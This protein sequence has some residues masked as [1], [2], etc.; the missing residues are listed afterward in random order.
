MPTYGWKDENTSFEVDI[1]RKMADSNDTPTLEEALEAG[2]T[3][4]EFTAARW[5]KV[6]GMPAVLNKSFL[7]GTKNRRTAWNKELAESY[8]LE[9]ESY[10][11]PQTSRKEINNEI[12]KL[13]QTKR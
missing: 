4:E 5:Q 6:I 12:R 9:A 1:Q 2:F 11:M 13:R 8:R 7:D 10:N 3:E